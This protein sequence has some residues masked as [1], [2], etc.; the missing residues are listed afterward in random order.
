VNGAGG[1]G[2]GAVVLIH[3]GLRVVASE[4]R[5]SLIGDLLGQ[6]SDWLAGDNEPLDSDLPDLQG[7]LALDLLVLEVS[8]GMQPL[9]IPCHRG[10]AMAPELICGCVYDVEG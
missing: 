3:D 5:L 10:V 6:D 1:F 4:S 9:S 7:V 2:A 8:L